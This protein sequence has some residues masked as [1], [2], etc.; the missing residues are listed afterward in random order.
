[1]SLTDVA[2]GVYAAC[3]TYQ[4]WL[5]GPP[6]CWPFGANVYQAANSMF[7]GGLKSKINPWPPLSALNQLPESR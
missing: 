7:C 6:I 1:M 4:R 2:P 5:A 3:M